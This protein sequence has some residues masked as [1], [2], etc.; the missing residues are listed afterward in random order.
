MGKNALLL[1][2]VLGLVLGLL[3]PIQ[4][5]NSASKLRVSPTR[6]EVKET[7][8]K[9][10]RSRVAV[11]AGRTKRTI[12]R[13]KTLQ[14]GPS[15][16][17]VKKN[18]DKR[19]KEL[20]AKLES[21]NLTY[22]VADSQG[23][24]G[25]VPEKQT[26]ELLKESKDLLATEMLSFSDEKKLAALFKEL[27]LGINRN[28][29]TLNTFEAAHEFE[30]LFMDVEYRGK[31][32]E[33]ETATEYEFKAS[34]LALNEVTTTDG[35]LK[36]LLTHKESKLDDNI[37]LPKFLVE[38]KE[39]QRLAM[40]WGDLDDFQ[41]QMTIEY[42]V[43]VRQIDSVRP[44][45]EGLVLRTRG[46]LEDLTTAEELDLA[47]PLNNG[48]LEELEFK[49][50]AKGLASEN[51]RKTFLLA[52]V[53]GNLHDQAHLHSPGKTPKR[54]LDGEP[55]ARLA[56]NDWNRRGNTY[57]E[58][59]ALQD[60]FVV[61]TTNDDQANLI[62]FDSL[63]NEDLFGIN[64]AFW[65]MYKNE[66]EKG[67]EEIDL[68]DNEYKSSF[69]G[70]RGKKT[71]DGDPDFGMEVRHMPLD[72]KKRAN[73]VDMVQR[74]VLTEDYG[75]PYYKYKMLVSGFE[76]QNPGLEKNSKEYNQMIGLTIAYM[77][78]NI[79]IDLAFEV[80]P[81]Y[82]KTALTGPV[83]TIIRKHEEKNHAVKML[84]NDWTKDSFVVQ[85]DKARSKAIMAQLTALRKIATGEDPD[86]VIQEFSF[87]SGLAELY[88][89]SLGL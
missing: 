40:S 2:I 12:E 10:P 54:I 63:N 55:A 76:K 46:G 1:I 9:V 48:R 3:I 29:G 17:G 77:H 84:I 56:K 49:R 70:F 5:A 52:E 30:R 72:P 34:G 87:K 4:P 67:Y 38:M 13:I 82:L 42:V 79:P 74:G 45:I 24:R 6:K 35:T 19:L 14:G 33:H 61:N 65:L 88:G 11:E 39:D 28:V 66:S 23:K 20:T 47:S 18:I 58:F 53:L 62:L 27:A 69:M 80:A 83:K 37:K 86:R 81:P 8:D 64:H 25:Q 15:K 26:L 85:G 73:F 16:A 60:G 41:K 71:Y 78:Y 31:V 57:L 7:A 51:L 43:K 75:I 68:L 21:W 44:K 59:I 32:L 89:K 36:P 22:Q 50:R